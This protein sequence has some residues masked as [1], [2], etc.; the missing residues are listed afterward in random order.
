[1]PKANQLMLF[2]LNKNENRKSPQEPYPTLEKS[3]LGFIEA[4]HQQ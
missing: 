1:M 4:V 3:S 2:E